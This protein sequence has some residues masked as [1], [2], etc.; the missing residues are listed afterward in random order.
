MWE[1]RHFPRMSRD[2]N[3]SGSGTETTLMV[4]GVG[5]LYTLADE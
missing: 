5:A 2:F 4:I 1:V 3:H